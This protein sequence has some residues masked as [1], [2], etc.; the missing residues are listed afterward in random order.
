[1]PSFNETARGY[2]NMWN[3]ISIPESKRDVVDRAAA[4][5][6]AKRH[7]Y[8][9]LVGVPW[10]WIAI[11][12]HLESSGDFK[13]HL[14][15][16]DSLQRRTVRVPAGRPTAGSPPFTWTESAIDALEM[17]KLHKVKDWSIPRALYEWER[18]NG[19][20]Y[21]PRKINS[22]Y[23]WS[24]ST[25]YTSGKYV[26][27]GKYDPSAVSKQIGAAVLLRAMIDQGLRTD[28]HKESNHMEELQTRVSAFAG[29]APKLASA[30]TGA[31]TDQWVAQE[32]LREAL[33]ADDSTP[34]TL[35]GVIGGG[36]PLT[37]LIAALKAAETLFDELRVAVPVADALPAP[38]RS[39]RTAFDKLFPER[40]DGLKTVIG[41][42]LFVALHV[43]D[44]LGVGGILTSAPVLEAGKWFAGTLAGVGLISKIER[45]FLDMRK[46]PS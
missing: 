42:G 24:F 33:K 13:T 44:I 37:G 38:P 2:S 35:L 29:I 16:G 1:M 46:G 25:H 11:T 34:E 22:P 32:V 28:T 12:H 14:H 10:W 20:G 31:P 9:N 45:F 4:R 17:K 43:L 40:L 5:I 15:N 19:F 41:V 6:L 36:L 21:F 39:E 26:S 27:D 8:G 23:L 30:I 3:D 18:Y 7:H